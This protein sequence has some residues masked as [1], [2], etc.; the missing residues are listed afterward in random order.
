M[1]RKYF[2]RDNS[3]LLLFMTLKVFVQYLLIH[4]VYDLQRDEYLHL[5]QANHPAWGYISLPPFSSWVAMAIKALGNDVFWVKFFPAL[6]GAFTIF[7]AWKIVHALKGNLFAKDPG[8][9]LTPGFRFAP[10]Q[11][12]VP[13]QFI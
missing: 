13:A 12:P 3:I 1:Y 10:A 9:L 5:D 4:P 7:F 6:F 11:Y 8:G 2:T